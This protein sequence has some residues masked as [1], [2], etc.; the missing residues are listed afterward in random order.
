[1]FTASPVRQPV[2]VGLHAWEL[3]NLLAEIVVSL[4]HQCQ[5]KAVGFRRINTKSVK[6]QSAGITLDKFIKIVLF[7]FF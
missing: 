1:M 3:L 7:A 4:P 2:P 6:L 5:G